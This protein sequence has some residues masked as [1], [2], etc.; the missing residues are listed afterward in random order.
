MG[1]AAHGAACWG[2]QRT[3]ETEMRIHT[4]STAWF[5]SNVRLCSV[6]C[7]V[8]GSPWAGRLGAG[9]VTLTPTW[10]I[11][12]APVG[13]ACGVWRDDEIANRGPGG[14]RAPRETRPITMPHITR[15]AIIFESVDQI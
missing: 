4:I 2:H 1:R 11:L 6:I 10:L 15:I 12:M 14:G 7:T 5:V 8:C 9:G 13:V 3:D